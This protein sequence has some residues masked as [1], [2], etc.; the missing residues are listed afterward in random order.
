MHLHTDRYIVGECAN[1]TASSMI[2]LMR[3]EQNSV[4]A[5]NLLG[6]ALIARST[7][8]VYPQVIEGMLKRAKS[9]AS[10]CLEG[11]QRTKCL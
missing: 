7:F 9:L 5:V 10:L 1:C 2:Q 4:F 8:E 6:D 11:C 3:R